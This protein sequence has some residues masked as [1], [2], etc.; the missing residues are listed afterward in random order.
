VHVYIKTPDTTNCETRHIIANRTIWVKLSEPQAW[1]YLTTNKQ[2]VTIQ[3]D[4][5]LESKI[6]IERIRKIKLLKNCKLTTTAVLIK[7]KNK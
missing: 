1:I 3:C 5:Q 4:D 7:T 2:D 6:I